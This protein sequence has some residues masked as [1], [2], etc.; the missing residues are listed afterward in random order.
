MDELLYCCSCW[1]ESETDDHLL[2]CPKR[3]QYR[4][5]IHQAINCLGNDVDPI[6]YYDILLH[7]ITR[8]L[9]GTRQ[10]QYIVSSKCK[11][12]KDY[13]DRIR[14]NQKGQQKSKTI[15]SNKIKKRLGGITYCKANLSKTGES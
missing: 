7:G 5:E 10:T 3:A 2:Q 14:Q 1:A 8:Y 9:N 12:K 6:L 4:N 13:W 15:S 11:P